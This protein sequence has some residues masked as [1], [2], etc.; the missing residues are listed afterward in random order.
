[1]E[2]HG[3]NMKLRPHLLIKNWKAEHEKKWLK[4]W[5][6]EKLTYP[7]HRWAAER[8][9]VREKSDYWSKTQLAREGASGN[10]ILG[11]AEITKTPSFLNS[12]F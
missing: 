10:F 2:I 11:E 3:K 7:C 8:E 1:M 4:E 6:K 5:E 9:R 12:I